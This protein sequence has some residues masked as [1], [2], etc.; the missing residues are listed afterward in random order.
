MRSFVA[1]ELP[2]AVRRQLEGTVAALRRELPPARWV[3][4]E[5]AHLTL[6]FLGEADV[7]VLETLSGQ[8]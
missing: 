2:D 3:R 1:I 4:L 6:K 7:G 5:N 8:L